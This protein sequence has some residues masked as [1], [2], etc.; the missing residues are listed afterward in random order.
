MKFVDVYKRQW[1][2]S[3][4]ITI[5]MKSMLKRNPLYCI[6]YKPEMVQFRDM[7]LSLRKENTGGLRSMHE[8]WNSETIGKG[9]RSSL[10]W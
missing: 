7:V 4:T 9:V 10:I 3:V 2:E 6:A 8:I 1:L 5:I